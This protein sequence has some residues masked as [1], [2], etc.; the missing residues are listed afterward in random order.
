MYWLQKYPS[1]PRQKSW[2]LGYILPLCF[3]IHWMRNL[4]PFGPTCIHSSLTLSLVIALIITTFVKF[5]GTI[6]ILRE[7]NLGLDRNI[8]WIFLKNTNK[9]TSQITFPC[10]ICHSSIQMLFGVRWK[11]SIFSWSYKKTKMNQAYMKI[12]D[13]KFGVYTC[14]SAF[15]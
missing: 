9:K 3:V 11:T 10:R 8:Y 15:S 4:G 1:W 2:L 7:W 6:I 5:K 12:A 14:S 13:L